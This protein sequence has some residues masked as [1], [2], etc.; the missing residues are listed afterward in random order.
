MIE[1]GKGICQINQWWKEWHQTS[2][3]RI[4]LAGQLEYLL[5]WSKLTLLSITIKK[6]GGLVGDQ[7]KKIYSLSGLLDGL[8]DSH[9]MLFGTLMVGKESI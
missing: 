9:L 6:E 5:N 4:N 3:V 7:L 2:Y 8:S 1:A